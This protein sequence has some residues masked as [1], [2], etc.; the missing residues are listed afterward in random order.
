[1]YAGSQKQQYPRYKCRRSMLQVMQCGETCR[2]IYAQV[3]RITLTFSKAC[4]VG[5]YF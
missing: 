4:D 1:M 5:G 2:L 3:K